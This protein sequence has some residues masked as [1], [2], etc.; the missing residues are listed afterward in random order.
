MNDPAAP[1]REWSGAWLDLLAFA[2][3][4]G[5]AWW[6]RWQATDLIWSL[7]LSSLVVG[8]AMIVWSIFGPILFIGSHA[9]LD[10]RELTGI[11]IGASVLGGAAVVL[12][13]LFLLA[14][15][16]FHFGM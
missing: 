6:E 4:L 9:W 16:T 13:A 10:R 1:R 12:G 11:S 2:L 7:W 3:G 8:Y 5:V 15:F 14:F